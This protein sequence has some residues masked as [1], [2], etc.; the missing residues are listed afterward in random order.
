MNKKAVKI[1]VGGTVLVS[2]F[3]AA[4]PAAAGAAVYVQEAEAE[5]VSME[6]EQEYEGDFYPGE[7]S[8]EISEWWG[9]FY[10]ED[11]QWETEYQIFDDLQVWEEEGNPDE[12][13]DPDSLEYLWSFDESEL[14]GADPKRA[15]LLEENQKT[16]AAPEKNMADEIWIGLYPLAQY[17]E[18]PTGCEVTSLTMALNYEGFDVSIGEIADR[19]LE[20]GEPGS[21]SY[22]EI[23]WGDPRSSESFGCFAPVIVK[24][25]NQ[26]LED[27]G[28]DKRAVDLSGTELED[29]YEELRCGY[30][31]LVWGSMYID[32][33]IVEVGSWE[34]DGE[35]VTWPGN[36]HC[37][38]LVGFDTEENTVRVCDPLRGI[39]VYDKDQFERHYDR[40]ERQAIVI[41][42]QE[43][44]GEAAE[45]EE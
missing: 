2:A 4:V 14:E 43:R 31:V 35:T 34:I 38:V 12:E 17:P 36:E 22:R 20:K 30:P 32:T 28:S 33:D 39:M 19:Y 23:F 24:A 25:A 10:P 6:C 45:K 29:L 3:S 13:A 7:A 5:E 40:L 11:P 18:F 37:M 16:E 1:L 41:K 8:P 15:D 44:S 27:Q 9:G 26:Y 42:K 21:K